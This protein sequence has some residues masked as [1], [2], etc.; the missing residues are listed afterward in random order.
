MSHTRHTSRIGWAGRVGRPRWRRAVRATA[1]GA[2]LALT[3]VVVPEGSVAPTQAALV[4]FQQGKGV[5]VHPNTVWVLAVGSD[6]RP[7]QQMLRA[8]GDA[9]QLVG[10]NTKT[11]AATAIG[12]PRDSWV[13]IPGH[14]ANRINSALYFGGPQLLGRVVGDLVGVQPDYV[15][16]TRFKGMWNLVNAIGGI[17]V[18]NPRYFDDP[19]LRPQ[20]YAAGMVDLRGPGATAF[21]RIRKSLPGGDFDRSA[22]QQRVLRGIQRKVSKRAQQP[23]FVENGVLAVLR[24]LHTDL[25]PVELFKLAQAGAV[26]KRSKVTNCVLPGSIA[27]VGGASVVMPATGTARRWGNQARHSAVIKNC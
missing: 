20:G 1:L 18:R 6:A 27:N 24:H 15:F 14:G 9:L 21:A 2:V 10:V 23:G 4:K 17:R 26:V 12:I 5:D 25:D 22:N 19:D 11:G 3:A 13:S 8:R 7:G 16:V